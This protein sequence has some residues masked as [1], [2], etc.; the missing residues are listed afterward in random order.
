MPSRGRDVSYWGVLLLLLRREAGRVFVRSEFKPC[1]NEI[2]CTSC[3][4]TYII[5]GTDLLWLQQRESQC[6]WGQHAEQQNVTGQTS[7]DVTPGHWYKVTLF[8]LKDTKQSRSEVCALISTYTTQHSEGE[9]G[10]GATQNKQ[11]RGEK[12]ST[13]E[14]TDGETEHSQAE[15]ALQRSKSAKW[16]SLICSHGSAI[17]LHCF[18][19]YVRHRKGVTCYT[20]VRKCVWA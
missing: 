16:S 20:G 3:L 2:T 11:Q 18:T 4:H 7:S 10:R 17:A 19:S 12:M 15:T 1:C 13:E 5:G 6:S 9:V 14:V 8:F